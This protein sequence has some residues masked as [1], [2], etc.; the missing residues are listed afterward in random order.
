MIYNNILE[1][2]GSTPIVK[3]SNLKQELNLKSDIYVKVESFNPGGSVKDRAVFMMIKKAL[4]DKTINNNTTIIE[5]TSGNT[6]IALAMVCAVYKLKLIIVMPDN[7]SIERRKLM[8]QYG[9]KLIL[10]KGSDGMNGAISMANEINDSEKNSF[11]LSQ[12]DNINNPLAHYVNTANEILNEDVS[13]DILVAGIGTGGTISGLSK[14]LKEKI[15]IEVVG[16]E[17]KESPFLSE[18]IKGAHKI[19]GIGAGFIPK[20]LDLTLVD[21]VMSVKGD[22]AILMSQLLCE[23]EGIGAGISSGAALKCAT[24]IAINEENKNILVI[25]PDTFERYLSTELF[26]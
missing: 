2:I 14:A 17:P 13:F 12:F 21:K 25:L 20:N 1:T 7:M 8:A 22:D 11:M 4:E 19:Q 9:A 10:S 23:I 16:V 5:A 26:K 15:E 6:G 18:F 3:L 24:Q